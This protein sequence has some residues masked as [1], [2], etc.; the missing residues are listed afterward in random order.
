MS[1]WERK[2]NFAKKAAEASALK[3]K[4]LKEEKEREDGNQEPSI[5]TDNGH[6]GQDNEEELVSAEKSVEEPGQQLA[7]ER[8]PVIDQG[9]ADEE[10][11]IAEEE[12]ESASP[13]Q[14]KDT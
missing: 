3:R 4:Q 11:P 1:N 8:E 12:K 6:D 5:D 14:R 7:P 13:W 10:E 9:P 2:K